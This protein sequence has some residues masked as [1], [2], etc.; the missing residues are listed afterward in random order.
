MKYSYGIMDDNR[1]ILYTPQLFI[2]T[3]DLLVFPSKDFH[4]WHG[5]LKEYIDGLYQINSINM[6]KCKSINMDEFNLAS[7][8]LINITE[9]LHHLFDPERTP[10]FSYQYV[11]TLDE[12][13]TKRRG[14]WYTSDMMKCDMRIH[15]KPAINPWVKEQN[16]MEIVDHAVRELTMVRRKKQK[17]LTEY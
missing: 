10:D 2:K 3:N 6:E 1:I 13:Y 17:K 15:L 14:N 8:L 9:E 12:E 4:K 16:M 5:D 11:S 7:G